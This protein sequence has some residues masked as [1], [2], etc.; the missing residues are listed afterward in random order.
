MFNNDVINMYHR[1][2][3]EIEN[4]IYQIISFH[5]RIDGTHYDVEGVNS[6]L[7]GFN[8]EV[9]EYIHGWGDEYKDIFIPLSMLT[10]VEEYDELQKLAEKAEQERMELKTKEKQHE[11]EKR[12][13]EAREFL[14]Q[15]N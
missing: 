11:I 14:E 15:H 1:H 13:K 3:N 7:G 2:H 10:N 8:V 12:V 4:V 9:S 6:K 5:G